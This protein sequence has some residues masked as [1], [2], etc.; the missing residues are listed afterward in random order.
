LDPALKQITVEARTW[1]FRILGKGNQTL[2]VL[3]GALGSGNLL[4]QHLAELLPDFHLMI[5]DYSPGNSVAEFLNV[6]EAILAAENVRRPIVYG[7]SFGGLLAQCWARRNPD[8]IRALI[9]FGAAAPDTKRVSTHRRMLKLL[10]FLP[11]PALRLAMKLA[12]IKITKDITSN[13]NLW[14]KELQ[15]LASTIQ[16]EDLASRYNTA[17]DFDLN[18]H[19]KSDDLHGMQILLLE[20]SEDRVANQKVRESMRGLYPHAEIVTIQGAGH[21]L[22]LTHPQQWQSAVIKFILNRSTA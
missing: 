17:L 10:P 13:K 16:R 2:V 8:S 9:L 15:S 22:L 11:M 20:G 21:S 4:A 14:R 7:G 6:F 12:A 1:R 19:F 5:P 3:P 18:S